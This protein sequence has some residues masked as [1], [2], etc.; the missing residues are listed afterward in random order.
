MILSRALARGVPRLVA[1]ALR[2]AVLAVRF[3]STTSIPPS[4][5]TSAPETT[6]SNNLA[7]AASEKEENQ[8]GKFARK[9]KKH[10][11]NRKVR[12]ISVQVK[13]SVDSATNAEVGEAIDILE[14]GI[15][16]LREI[17]EAEKIPE[18]LLYSVFQPITAVLFDKLTA[19]DALSGSRSVA[20]VL[21]MLITQRIAH[22]YHFLKAAEHSIKSNSNEEGYTEVLQ[23]WLRYLEYVKEN[24]IG[25]MN[26]VIK[27]P[28]AAYKERNFDSRDLQN[29]SY[30]SY[31]MHCLDSGIDYSVNDA[32]K[33]L[34]I[35]ES[36]RVPEKFH[37]TNTIRRLGLSQ[38]K[39]AVAKYERK[40][41]DLN[42]KAM[43]PN[44]P[45]VT[46][47]IETAIAQNNPAMLNALFDQMKEASVTN[48]VAISEATFNR[49]MS[50]YIELFKFDEVIDI[51][52]NLLELKGKP[53]VATWDLV[54]KAMGHPT[55]VKEMSAA[56]RKKMVENIEN[57]VKTMVASGTKM[58]ARTLAVVVGAFANLNRFDLV[59][60]YL[61]EY[62][63][64]PVVHLTKNN[65]LLGLI[66]NKNITQ[67]EAK[68]KEYSEKDQSFSPS[69]GTMNAY[70]AHYVN[71]GNNEAVD[72]VI[73]YMRQRGIEQNVAT[74]TT[75]ISHYFKM[76][77]SKGMVPDVSALMTL[78][79]GI[80]PHNNF[81]AT[82]IIDGLAKDGVNLE[83]ARTMFDH[84]CKE[85]SRL[86][87]NGGLLTTMI[88]AELDFG[89]VY[90]AEE[91]FDFYIANLKNDTRAWNMMIAALLPKQEQ[92]ALNYYNRLLEQAPFNVK[93]NY[94]TY[95]FILDHFVK[96]G[97]DK[98]IQWTL[99]EISKSNLSD[100]GRSLP[101]MIYRLRLKYDLSPELK[102]KVT[103]SNP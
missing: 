30:F 67:A 31:V 40:I 54:I 92:L 69:T 20:D 97:N 81:T 87:Y 2:S 86:K 15:S 26:F 12:D 35:Q 37:V 13:Q 8:K 71:S 83:A 77:R 103:K 58:N 32:M 66:S 39:E 52:R 24:G 1:Q 68:M 44:G 3:S 94:F 6:E 93:P 80:I 73:K 19:D 17:Q 18:D 88:T 28:F 27:L 95:Y 5:S 56:E 47:R 55:N 76:Y 99:D 100:L 62:K 89:S 98:R 42:I 82:T 85:N 36:S 9:G 59:D 51:F 29:L 61:E 96:T 102:A 63:D 25:R 65:I 84:F 23:L 48:E 33:L 90:S 70:L 21:D 50:A 75:L 49:I 38:L 74:V 10:I 64:V 60:L 11:F 91:L 79:K 41:N 46:K 14:E 4:E 72:G 57:T 22:N 34:Q 78:L 45:Y 16:Y 101:R 53:S 7:N 43:D